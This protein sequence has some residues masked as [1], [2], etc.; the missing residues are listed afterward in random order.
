MFG[1][2]VAKSMANLMIIITQGGRNSTQG[3]RRV[4]PTPIITNK[5]MV[6]MVTNSHKLTYEVCPDDFWKIAI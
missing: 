4:T 5:K 6:Q 1:V 3:G 2:R